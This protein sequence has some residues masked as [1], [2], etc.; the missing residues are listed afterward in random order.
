MVCCPC[1]SK[2]GETMSQSG[3]AVAQWVL[4]DTI[5]GEFERQ[6]F[7]EEQQRLEEDKKLLEHERRMLEQ[8]R[9]EF[10]WKKK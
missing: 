10:R 1:I 8:E 9:K 7:E 2:G 5:E 6:D 4:Q 3:T